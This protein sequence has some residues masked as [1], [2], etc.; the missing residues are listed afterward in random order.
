M[1]TRRP[2]D[3]PATFRSEDDMGLVDPA[4]AAPSPLLTNSPLSS[5]SKWSSSLSDSSMDRMLAWRCFFF[6][7]SF[8]LVLRNLTGG[9]IQ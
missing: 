5:I 2:G 1:V 3:P 4:A 6:L 8:F 7:L 9:P